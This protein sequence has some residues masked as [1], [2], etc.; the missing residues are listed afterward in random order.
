[1]GKT[2]DGEGREGGRERMREDVR[3]R[4]GD[5]KEKAEKEEE[6]EKAA[7][8]KDAPPQQLDPKDDYQVQQAL[9][10]LKTMNFKNSPGQA[11]SVGAGEKESKKN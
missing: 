6:E 11:K 8:S 5:Q 4:K 9:N 2:E 1:M 3:G 7:S 10:F